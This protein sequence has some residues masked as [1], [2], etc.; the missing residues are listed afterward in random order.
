MNLYLNENHHEEE[1]EAG[2]DQQAKRKGTPI[3]SSDVSTV[4]QAGANAG[5][6]ANDVYSRNQSQPNRNEDTVSPSYPSTA[7][8]S[9]GGGHVNTL[10]T[11][12]SMLMML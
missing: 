9:V 3:T 11:S 12:P 1:L 4:L 7:N 10:P 5:G 6:S 8:W 2:V